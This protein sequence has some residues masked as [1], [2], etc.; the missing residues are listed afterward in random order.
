M[1]AQ[2]GRLYAIGRGCSQSQITVT[3]RSDGRRLVQLGYFAV[4]DDEKRQDLL[5]SRAADNMKNGK[6][7][8][9]AILIVENHSLLKWLTVDLVENAG[10]TALH[11]SNADEAVAI[12]ES[13]SDVA[14]VLTSV[15][16]PGSMDGLELAQTVLTRWPVI[17]LI[18]ASGRTRSPEYDLPIGSSFFTKPYDSKAM[19]SEMKSLIGPKIGNHD[20]VSH[21]YL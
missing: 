19:I 7:S 20:I 4:E 8:P 2:A 13:R 17:K 12:L 1:P 6:L 21:V 18:I 3:F 15:R 5:P 11:A 10:F 9:R 14:L 16:M